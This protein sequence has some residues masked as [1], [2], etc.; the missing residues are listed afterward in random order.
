MQSFKDFKKVNEKRI[1]DSHADIQKMLQT[2]FLPEY[3]EEKMMDEL[4]KVVKTAIE[5][6]IKKYGYEFKK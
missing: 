4:E 3:A 2:I 5:P 6:V 1:I